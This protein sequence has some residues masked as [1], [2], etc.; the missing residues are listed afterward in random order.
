[1]RRWLEGAY[2]NTKGVAFCKRTTMGDYY[3]ILY[4]IILYCIILYYI[5][6]YYNYVYI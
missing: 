2:C 3:I 5:I 6:L 4:Y 1:M